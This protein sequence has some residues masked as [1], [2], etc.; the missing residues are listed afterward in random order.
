MQYRYLCIFLLGVSFNPKQSFAQKYSSSSFTNINN[1]QKNNFVSINQTENLA[2]KEYFTPTPTVATQRASSYTGNYTSKSY[3]TDNFESNIK[4]VTNTSINS[5]VENTDLI[6]FIVDSNRYKS[7]EV[8]NTS[9]KIA[10][11]NNWANISPI[12]YTYNKLS[13]ATN[14]LIDNAK[15]LL[16]VPYK[17]GGNT[18]NDGMDCS[19]FVR[20]VYYY[21]LGIILP[22]RSAEIGQIGTYIDTYSLKEGDLVFFNTNGQSLSHLGIYMGNGQFIHAPST[23]SN[24]RIDKLSSRYWSTRYEGA[25]RIANLN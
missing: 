16:G 3:S 10:S 25:K 1:I 24:I 6:P 15:K 4:T 20:Y 12:S 17:Y 7:T 2:K 9:T 8:N 14:S 23:G 18:P 21:T 19:G 22:R 5:P 13:Y 11:N